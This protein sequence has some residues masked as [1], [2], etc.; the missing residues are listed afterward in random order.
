MLE[1]AAAL[2][3]GQSRGADK[4]CVLAAE[5]AFLRFLGFVKLHLAG[6]AVLRALIA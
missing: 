5:F 1:A 4:Q 6:T 3:R 2:V